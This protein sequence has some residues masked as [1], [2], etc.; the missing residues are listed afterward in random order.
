MTDSVQLDWRRMEEADIPA[1]FVLDHH[2]QGH[3]WTPGNFRE[4]LARG[5]DGYARVL[6]EPGVGI[7]GYLC[8]WLAADELHI[9][10]LGVDV[11]LR[12]KGLGYGMVTQAHRWAGH[13]GA[14]LAH[15][16]VRASNAAALAL[17][18]KLGYRRVGVRTG[19]YVDNGED[20]LLLLCDLAV[21]APGTS[22]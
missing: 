10:T 7:V 3:P 14:T 6:E 1:V 17:Y 9:G 2:C 13:R 22:A 19:Y 20:A 8:A 5:E 12:R 15:L 11:E 4:E 16:E 18:S 21:A